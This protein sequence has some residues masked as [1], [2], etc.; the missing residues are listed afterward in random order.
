[1]KEGYS[2]K[3]VQEGSSCGKGCRRDAQRKGAR[4]KRCWRDAGGVSRGRDT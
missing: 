2:G 4:A 1:M 3:G